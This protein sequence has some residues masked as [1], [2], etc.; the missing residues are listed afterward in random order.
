M[1]HILIIDDEQ[2]I[3]DLLAYNLEKEGYSVSKALDG[4]KGKE[5]ALKLIP[6]L[7]V[8]DLMLPGMD[9]L[10]LCRSLRGDPK[11]AAIP[12]LML[13]AK[14]EE[15]DKVIGLEIGA[16]DYVT[17]PFGIREIGA[18]VRALLRRAVKKNAPEGEGYI[19][20]DLSVDLSTHEVRVSSEL[21][22]LSP[23]E[24]KLLRFFITHTERVYS[25]DQLLD[26]V[27]GDESFVEPRTVDVHIR[28]LREKIKPEGSL[29]KTIR[30]TGY[31]FSCED[32]MELR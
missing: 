18:R 20:G 21:I 25:R 29:I 27:W 16:D 32:V 2:D 22:N 14:S 12:V 5:M 7:I 28:R 13:T 19:F 10:E 11:T 8:L 31:R 1:S 17:K 4:L 6:D 15:I 9:G 3:I 24:F 30:G 23:L 26:K